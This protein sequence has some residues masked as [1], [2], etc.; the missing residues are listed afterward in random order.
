V[1]AANC[2]VWTELLLLDCTG[3]LTIAP[4]L[5]NARVRLF[6]EPIT[7]VLKEIKNRLVCECGAANEEEFKFRFTPNLGPVIHNIEYPNYP[8]PN[9][10]KSWCPSI[11]GFYQDL[12]M[13]DIVGDSMVLPMSC[14]YLK[15]MSGEGCKMSIV[16]GGSDVQFQLATKQCSN[17]LPY[18][19][20]TCAGSDCEKFAYPCSSDANCGSNLQCVDPFTYEND[21]PRAMTQVDNYV[22]MMLGQVGIIDEYLVDYCATPIATPAWDNACSAHMAKN[23]YNQPEFNSHT[24]KLVNYIRSMF[25]VGAGSPTDIPK[26]CVPKAGFFEELTDVVAWDGLLPS[27]SDVFYDG[28]MNPTSR[29]VSGMVTINNTVPLLD[30]TCGG[31]FIFMPNHSL[32]FSIGL[33]RIR[34]HTEALFTL[35]KDIELCRGNLK[36]TP[37]STDEIDYRYMVMDPA[38]LMYYLSMTSDEY[39]SARVKISDLISELYK[40]R[41]GNYTL[42]LPSSCNVGQ[43]INGTCAFAYT[44]LKNI[45]GIE[46]VI[47]VKMSRCAI[48]PNSLPTIQIDCQ[49]PGCMIF[50]HPIPCA[51]TDLDC[52]TGT[53]CSDWTQGFLRNE[54]GIL[55]NPFRDILPL[56]DTCTDD[57][58]FFD[59]F[60]RMTKKFFQSNVP[61]DKTDMFYCGFNSQNSEGYIAMTKDPDTQKSTVVDLV[62]Y[63]DDSGSGCVPVVPNFN[64]TGSDDGDDDID[65]GGGGLPV[66]AGNSIIPSTILLAFGLYFTG[67]RGLALFIMCTLMLAS[68]QAGYMSNVYS[69]NAY[70]SR[71]IELN[72]TT[73]ELTE[74]SSYTMNFQIYGFA[75]WCDH[76]WMEV[77]IADDE[78]QDYCSEGCD[79]NKMRVERI[80][81]RPDMNVCNSN[82]TSVSYLNFK[83]QFSSRYSC[84]PVPMFAKQLAMY[85][86]GQE[87]YTVKLNNP[88]FD[89]YGWT[90]L[91][92]ST[93]TS[94]SMNTHNVNVTSGTANVTLH[95]VIEDPKTPPGLDFKFSDCNSFERDDFYDNDCETYYFNSLEWNQLVDTNTYTYDVVVEVPQGFANGTYYAIVSINNPCN[96]VNVRCEDNT[97]NVWDEDQN[98]SPPELYYLNLISYT[99]VTGDAE[100][101]FEVTINAQDNE[102]GS[103]E[104]IYMEFCTKNDENYTC[105]SCGASPS[106]FQSAGNSTASS[107]YGVQNCSMDS[108]RDIGSYNLKK[109]ELKDNLGNYKRID[110]CDHY[111]SRMY[112][113]LQD[114]G[115]FYTRNNA[116]VIGDKQSICDNPLLA[117]LNFFKQMMGDEDYNSDFN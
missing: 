61:A 94:F 91:E 20:V 79:D 100:A 115:F 87:Q 35:V 46:N 89:I 5:V 57:A 110:V 77:V 52:P 102:A 21:E 97:L 3:Q 56:S 59:F 76:I 98:L 29:P 106:S 66:S 16:M 58:S 44:G 83:S 34:S 64:D 93:L 28:R 65:N 25:G 90:D 7:E 6:S 63:C 1:L 78:E 41:P 114:I 12:N 75:D 55:Q 8:I 70:Y 42:D 18:V 84:M 43:V 85:I 92:P 54:S 10:M 22:N 36:G 19:S 2:Q 67:H 9:N 105:I 104:Y 4:S 51:Q 80:Q 14:S 11:P 112:P 95:V 107:W 53:S 116:I 103:I 38:F 86:D 69:N 74:M 24:M 101:Y 50:T 48:S 81:F 27:Y 108:W 17:Y 39:E 13:T 113:Y 82:Y 47:R 117:P 99:N 60:N 32:E 71:R 72:D 49:G 31:N 15:W 111:E 37:I 40:M 33:T 23:S 73:I 62:A 26:F 30:V 68:A 96:E 88:N 109:I 45:S